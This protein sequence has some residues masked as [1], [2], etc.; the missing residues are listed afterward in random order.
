MKQSVEIL[1]DLSEVELIGRKLG[2]FS[3]GE[4]AE[5]RPWEASVLEEK[6]LAEP[7]ED[8]SLVGVRK[9]L[10]REEKSSTLEDISENFY[11][12]VSCEIKRLRREGEVEKARELKETVDSLVNLRVQKLIRM[13]VSSDVPGDIPPEEVFLMN[14]F[15]Q[16]LKIWR[17]RLFSLFEE[18]SEKEAGAHERGIRR[19][20]QGIVRDAADIQE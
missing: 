2:P 8:F 11:F 7:I 15:S 4:E 20:V 1:E 16:A 19:S 3:E 10:M 18:S 17:K 6:A 13:V 12:S 14:R 5:V 9:L